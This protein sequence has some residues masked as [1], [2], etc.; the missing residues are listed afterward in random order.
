MDIGAFV[1]RKLVELKGKPSDVLRSLEP[2]QVESIPISGKRSAKLA[3]WKDEISPGTTRVVVQG[4]RPYLLGVGRMTVKG[5][6]VD[7]SGAVRD[8]AQDQLYEFT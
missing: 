1:D 8:L 4:Y 5:F 2:C 3:V 7:F 6:T